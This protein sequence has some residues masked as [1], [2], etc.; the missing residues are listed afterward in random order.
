MT[1]A[2]IIYTRRRSF[3]FFKA[4]KFRAEKLFTVLLSL[5]C[6]PRDV[7]ELASVLLLLLLLILIEVTQQGLT[8]QNNFANMHISLK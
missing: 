8:K 7:A 1:S 5:F 2:R 4:N 6:L 3:F